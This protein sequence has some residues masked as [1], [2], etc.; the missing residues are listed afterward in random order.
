MDSKRG[1]GV[2][3]Y[4]ILLA[5]VLTVSSISTVLLGFFPGLGADSKISESDIYWRGVSIP[6][7][8]TEHTI[9]SENG[10]FYAVLKNS[11]DAGLQISKVSFLTK[12]LHFNFTPQNGFLFSGE[13]RLYVIPIPAG[14]CGSSGTYELMLNITYSSQEISNKVQ[15]GQIPLVGSCSTDSDFADPQSGSLG[16]TCSNPNDC[17][18]HRCFEGI[19]VE[20]IGN[21]H[22]L[23]GFAC[24]SGACVP[25]SL[26]HCD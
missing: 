15:Y 8:I 24:S 16:A 22:C 2:I 11:A 1:Q 17:S 5:I 20:C 7:S 3:E 10:D 12:D 26:G 6:F 4:V 18:S 25:C 9:I 21:G 14:I 23:L 13:E 19:C